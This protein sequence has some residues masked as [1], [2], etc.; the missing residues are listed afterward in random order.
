MEDKIRFLKNWLGTGSV[1]VFGLPM[2]GKDTVSKRLSESLGGVY[3]SSGEILRSAEQKG[4]Q[5]VDMG[6]G[7]WVPQQQFFDIVL[8]YLSR[9][10][11]RGRALILGGVGRWVG[12][13]TQTMAALVNAGHPTSAVV[14]L[15]IGIEEIKRRFD[16]LS[17]VNDRGARADDADFSLVE[18]R[19]VEFRE[20]TLPV[21]EKYRELGLLVSIDAGLSRD[22]VFESAIE[23][24]YSF[25]VSQG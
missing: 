22:E 2:S 9:E 19:I 25:A 17:T 23:K 15:E 12:E 20:K 8:P 1:N 21:I 11:L 18:S 13:E 5:V 4:E 3:V 14:F 6:D 7:K 24:L 16:A 10:E